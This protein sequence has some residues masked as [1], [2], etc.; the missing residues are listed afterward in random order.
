[1]PG[2]ARSASHVGEGEPLTPLVRELGSW[3]AVGMPMGQWL[4]SL[5]RLEPHTGS[6]L[7][8]TEV[9]VERRLIADAG[10][11]AVETSM[12]S[13]SAWLNNRVLRLARGRPAAV[14]GE[15]PPGLSMATPIGG[16]HRTCPYE[17]ADRRR[18]ARRPSELV[19]AGPRAG[20]MWP[21]MAHRAWL[22]T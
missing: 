13:T 9:Q 20:P 8:C 5:H 7:A 22:V 19:C 1:M 16:G 4:V 17:R 18:W 14:A 15:P 10:Q 6:N 2:S 3:S 12:W 21:G 11:L